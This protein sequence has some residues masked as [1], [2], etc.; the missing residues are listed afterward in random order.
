MIQGEDVEW[1]PEPQ[2]DCLILLPLQPISFSP[3]PLPQL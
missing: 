2:A 1:G 3:A